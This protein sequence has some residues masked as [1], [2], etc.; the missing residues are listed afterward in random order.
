VKK[1]LLIIFIKLIVGIA[2][3]TYIVHKAA[4]VWADSKAIIAN[5]F[6]NRAYLFILSTLCFGTVIVLGTYRWKL[7][8]KAHQVHL[9]FTEVL[10][11]FFVGHFF[12]QFMPG[13]LAGGDIIKS[14]YVA[15]H[16]DT[17]K[18]EAVTT[19]FIDRM[20]GI[21]GLFGVLLFGVLVNLSSY[22]HTKHV[23]FVLVFLV[24]AA[25][26]LLLFFNKNLLKKIPGLARLVEK[27][28][29]R[30]FIARVYN[31]FNYYKDHKTVL[32]ITLVL[33]TM[34]HATLTLMVFLI[35]TGLGLET[36]FREYFVI[37][38]LVSF[39]GSIPVS[40]LGTVGILDGAYIYFF[41]SEAPEGSG[42]P[43]ALALLGRIIYA[44]WGLVGLLV[45]LLMRSR[46]GA[47]YRAATDMSELDVLMKSEVAK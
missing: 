38:P 14:Y 7:L 17:R 46:M 37:V 11:L 27:L 43:G 30:D 32:I 44:I 19:I 40:M 5:L 8:L 2:L 36:A 35:A 41:Q 15:T 4:P 47:S 9:R 6:R 24:G 18:H 10:K 39:V 26:A 21:F 33:S 20:V 31:A 42:I 12:S 16:T 25:F 28:P 1:K 34:V 13:G 3:V 23:I 29:Y 45:W 22:G